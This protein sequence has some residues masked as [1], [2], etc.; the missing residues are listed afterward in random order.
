[1]KVEAPPYSPPVEK[2]W[3][4][5]KRISSTGAQ[6]PTAAYV[7]SMP[8]AAVPIAIR[9]IVR[10]RTFLRPI[11]SPIGPKTMPPSG[12]TRNATAKVAKEDSSCTVSFPEGKK[13]L[14]MVPA[15]YA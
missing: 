14:P 5:R 3:S 8:I 10:A 15:R 13:T 1:M 6:N 11:L 2:P 4:S 9:I 7:G 12:R